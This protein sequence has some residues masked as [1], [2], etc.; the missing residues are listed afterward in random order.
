MCHLGEAPSLQV[1][2]LGTGEGWMQHALEALSSAFPGA[3][4]GVP[5]FDEGLA[6]LIMAAADY[7]VVPSRFEPCGLVV[8]SAARYGAIPI[9]TAVGGLRDFVVPEVSLCQDQDFIM[10]QVSSRRRSVDMS[11]L[12]SLCYCI[13]CGQWCK[14]NLTS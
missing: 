14:H 1:V 11:L 13:P 6:H 3:A 8:Q 9:A 12:R 7:V 5:R 2:L 4:A 10:Y